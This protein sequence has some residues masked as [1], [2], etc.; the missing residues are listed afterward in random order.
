MRVTWNPELQRS[1]VIRKPRLALFFAAALLT[2]MSLTG[3]RPS[4][5]PS[6]PLSQLNA[7]ERSGYAVY[8]QDCASCHYANQTGDLHGPSLFA[9]YRRKYL[10]SGAP[11]NDDRVS[12]AITDGHG[13]MPGFGNQ[14]SPQQLQ[15]L[16]AYL[17]TL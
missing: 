2:G 8:R 7:Q 6:K 10:P 17:H 4:L 13:I 11:A 9:L 15:D 16:L 1:N 14:I 5:A 12:A 3:C